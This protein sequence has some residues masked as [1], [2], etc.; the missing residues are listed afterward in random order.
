MRFLDLAA[1]ATPL[2]I[3]AHAVPMPGPSFDVITQASLGAGRLAG[4]VAALGTT[5]GVAVYA[6]ATLLV[7]STLA[8]A[9]P[10]LVTTIQILGGHSCL[11]S[12][13]VQH[14]FL[15]SWVATTY[16][17]KRGRV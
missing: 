15:Q 16:G 3:Y 2:A 8:T 4:M 11:R 9:L 6:T 5:I 17:P 12:R 1:V 14:K 13:L 10:W 7:I